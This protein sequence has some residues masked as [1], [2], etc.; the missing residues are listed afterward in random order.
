MT[1]ISFSGSSQCIG[2]TCSLW[3]IPSLQD[4]LWTT[5]GGSRRKLGEMPAHGGHSKCSPFDH[6]LLAH[7]EF[8]KVEPLRYSV[9]VNCNKY[10]RSAEAEAAILASRDAPTVSKPFHPSMGTQLTYVKPDYY[11]RNPYTTYSSYQGYANYRHYVEDA[12]RAIGKH[13][14]S[15]KASWMRGGSNAK[16]NKQ[17]TRTS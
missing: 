12:L 15:L 13:F 9:Y 7:A 3:H 1:K 2:W 10:G 16:E 8:T 17:S 4:V 5:R 11:D 14:N 6:D